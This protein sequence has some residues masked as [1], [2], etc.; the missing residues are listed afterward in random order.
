M[1]QTTETELESMKT[2]SSKPSGPEMSGSSFLEESIEQSFF[3]MHTSERV[4]QLRPCVP[5]HID[6]K[7]SVLYR[8]EIN[9]IN[10]PRGFQP[11]SN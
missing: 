5:L 11:G 10:T 3:S 1:S 8:K 4:P 2:I 6:L 7:S 9:S